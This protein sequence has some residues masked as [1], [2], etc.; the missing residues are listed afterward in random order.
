M[1][2]VG[3]PLEDNI[4]VNEEI[5]K[6]KDE[7]GILVETI[8]LPNFTNFC[9]S[10]C[11]SYDDTLYKAEKDCIDL[12]KGFRRIK[13]IC[14]NCLIQW[15]G[16]KYGSLDMK[17]CF[18]MILDDLSHLKM[19]YTKKRDDHLKFKKESETIKKRTQGNL[20]EKDLN[21][22]CG[23][24]EFLE[25][26]FVVVD[27]EG[28][29][30]LDFIKKCENASD[31][32]IDQIDEDEKYFLYRILIL[33]NNVKNFKKECSANGFYIKEKNNN[34]SFITCE[35][36]LELFIDTHSLELY[37]IFIHLKLVKLYIECFCRYG[38]PKKYLC[39]ICTEKKAFEK[40]KNISDNWKSDR[41]IDDSDEDET[42]TN[43][44]HTFINIE[45]E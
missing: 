28:V 45:S 3:L 31:E 2:L 10:E 22:E 12:I 21:I 40:F 32:V 4:D 15:D 25:E 42:D 38:L 24:Y 23:S 39:L 37:K 13:E 35:D 16:N 26:V 6:I 41:I 20:L 8:D 36:N 1:L 5:C 11:S 19:L 43:F 33:K 9:I 14:F 29:N 34:L 30:F 27:K 18:N 7:Y 17:E 44:A